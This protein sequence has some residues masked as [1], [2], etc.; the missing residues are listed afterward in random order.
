AG[1]GAGE[2]GIAEAEALGEALEA[3]QRRDLETLLQGAPS[4]LPMGVGRRR[5]GGKGARCE[6]LDI[7]VGAALH[8]ERV[9]PPQC[10]GGAAA[11]DL[12]RRQAIEVKIDDRVEEVEGDRANRRR[13]SSR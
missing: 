13:H 11:A 2:P 12:E 6:G 9:L 4:R 1:E 8:Q 10:G 5:A 3:E 7:E